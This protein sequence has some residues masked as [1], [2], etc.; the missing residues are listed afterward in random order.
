MYSL[1]AVLY[2]V[3]VIAGCRRHRRCLGAAR[4]HVNGM[5]CI[6]S[7]GICGL[8]AVVQVNSTIG[9][10]ASF[11]AIFRRAKIT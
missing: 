5:G 4:Q 8:F 11:N 10:S 9:E 1:L 3:A 2:H 6:V 7:S